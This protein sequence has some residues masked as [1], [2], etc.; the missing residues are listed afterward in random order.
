VS[1]QKRA[2][3]MPQEL[4]ELGEWRQIVITDNCKPIVCDKIKYFADP[5]FMPRLLPPVAVKPIDLNGFLAN[6]SVNLN[7]GTG[8]VP[9]PTQTTL[10][11]LLKPV[12][13][14]M[15]TVTTGVAPIAAEVSAMVDYLYKEIDWQAQH[16]A[17][18]PNASLVNESQQMEV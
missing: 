13:S 11:K 4:R 12:N 8:S 3:M 7:V 2:L 14:M 5:V 6:R 16:K 9:N 10:H 18:E 1:D 15:P 17:V